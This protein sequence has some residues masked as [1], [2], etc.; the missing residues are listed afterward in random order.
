MRHG[1]ISVGSRTRR[2]CAGGQSE[3]VAEVSS[4]SIWPELS[5]RLDLR[6]CR[7]PSRVPEATTEFSALLNGLAVCKG[8]SF[9]VAGP[10]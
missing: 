5:L 3:R 6:T 2:C 10:D 1:P 7:I 8:T 9:G 4:G